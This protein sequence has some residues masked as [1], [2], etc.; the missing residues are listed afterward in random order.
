[1][2]SLS[3]CRHQNLDQA[4]FSIQVEDDYAGFL[5]IDIHQQDNGT[6]E[7]KQTGLIK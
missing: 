7:L 6:I 1:V 3:N 2:K 4:A 5:G